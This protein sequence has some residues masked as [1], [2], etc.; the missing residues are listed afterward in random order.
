MDK[1]IIIAEKDNDRLD[2]FLAEVLDITRS[3][4]KK[5]I[6]EGNILVAGQKVKAGKA[7]GRA[8]L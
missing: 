8:M 2:V 5:L 1:Q 6:D 4:I 7:C 3:Q